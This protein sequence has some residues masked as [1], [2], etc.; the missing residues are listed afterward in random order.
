MNVYWP[1]LAIGQ[2]TGT[3]ALLVLNGFEPRIALP[4]MAD[5]DRLDDH[6]RSMLE[7]DVLGGR[8]AVVMILVPRLSFRFQRMQITS[9]RKFAP[10]HNLQWLCT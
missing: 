6:A 2:S 10:S 9:R 4:T 5:T 1:T 3:C 8:L 7:Y